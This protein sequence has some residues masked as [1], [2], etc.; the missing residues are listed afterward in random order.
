VAGA[1]LAGAEPWKERSG[2]G[3][4]LGTGYRA[5]QIVLEHEE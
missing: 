5:A 1:T 3:I 4:S 2:E